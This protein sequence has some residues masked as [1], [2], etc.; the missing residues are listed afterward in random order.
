MLSSWQLA[1][2]LKP[3][4][5]AKTYFQADPSHSIVAL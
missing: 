3:V 2:L 1:Q 4:G 5:K